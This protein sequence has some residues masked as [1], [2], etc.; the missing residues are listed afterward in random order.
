VYSY[1]PMNLFVA[2]WSSRRAPDP[3]RAERAV[4]DLVGALPFL[5]GAEVRAWQ[6]PSGAATAAWAASW[7][8]YA[9]AEGAHLALWAGRPVRW[10]PAGPA[11]G[12]SPLDAGFYLPPAHYWA[13]ALDGRFTAIRYDDAE[14]SL[15]AVAD[16]LGAY[17]LY[18]ADADGVTWIANRIEPLR[19]LVGSRAVDLDALASLLAGGWTLG[20]RP[21]WAAVRRVRPGVLSLHPEGGEGHR[22][23]LSDGDVARMCGAGFEPEAAARTLI[24][25]VRALADWPGRPSVVPVTG[26]RDSRLVL[27][28]ALRAGIAFDA[29][30]GGAPESPDVLSARAVCEA[31][32]IGHELVPA[33]PH[34]DPWATPAEAARVLGLTTSGTASLGDAAG[35]PLGPREGPPVLW[36]S[37][38][39]GEIA[40][41]YYRAAAG[42][43]RDA[44]VAGLERL[45]CGRRPGRAGPLSAEGRER[46]RVGIADWVEGRLARGAALEDLPDLFYVDERMGSW[47]GPT[48][49][50]VEWVRDTTSP[51]WGTR[52]LPHLLG[53]TVAER[54]AEALHAAVLRE[55]APELVDVPYAGG[56]KGGLR[57]KARRAV[58]EA[59]R[60]V[61]PAAGE[62]GI[63]PFD[64]VLAA[65]R[66]AAAAQ[67]D[68]VTWHVLDRDRV[69]G[70]LARDASALDEMSRHYV[71]RLATL[72][73]DP[74]MAEA[75]A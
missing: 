9:T 29:V 59:R 13:E 15:A 68:H 58:E 18:R 52:M 2:G 30:T 10:E 51:L 60:R 50:A 1:A 37:G 23:L 16:A 57:H 4:R 64:R 39:G 40:R 36:H 34:G 31:A 35:F 45:F 46:V 63:D 11:E 70:L 74:A 8:G 25:S 55:L 6:A 22:E 3:R 73:L 38:Q 19:A 61:A 49:G 42:R 32:G 43:D 47:A 21:A 54:E 65:V 28:G 44:V 41:G 27:A 17:P 7:P 33:D 66:D 62:P 53:P 67:P 24:D 20:G 56:G 5:D 26:G 75:H 69:D 12:H 72:F 14:R 48:H 71:W